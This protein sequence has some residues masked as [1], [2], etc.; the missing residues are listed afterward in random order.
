MADKPLSFNPDD[1]GEFD[2]APNPADALAAFDTATGATCVPPGVYL[3][4]LESGELTLTKAGKQAYRL[5]FVV[6]QPS[7]HAG[8]TL[9]RYFTFANVANANRAKVALAPLGLRTSADLKR[10]PFPEAGRTIIC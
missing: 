7:E 5:R 9:W 3:A 8:F 1:L 2:R 4:R 6:V 10:I